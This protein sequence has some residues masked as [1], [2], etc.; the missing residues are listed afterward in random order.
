MTLTLG[1]A[2]IKGVGPAIF[3][4]LKLSKVFLSLA[5]DKLPDLRHC[6]LSSAIVILVA[7]DLCLLL[8]HL[9]ALHLF[10]FLITGGPE[11]ADR[12]SC[13]HPQGSTMVIG[14]RFLR[15]PVA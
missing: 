7:S 3:T 6:L 10:F 15:S 11:S 13:H 8:R 9:A 2:V 14:L 5:H 1:C 4:I 12:W